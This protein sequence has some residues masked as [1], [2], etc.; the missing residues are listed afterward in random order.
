[1]MVTMLQAD[2]DRLKRENE[3]LRA[4]LER[5]QA[6][7]YAHECPNDYCQDPQHHGYSEIFGDAYNTL[8]ALDR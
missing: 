4:S 6:I 2:L 7:A 8:Y 1:M 3:M 5:I